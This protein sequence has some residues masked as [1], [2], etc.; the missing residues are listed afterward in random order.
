MSGKG[1]KSSRRRR[2]HTRRE[3]R[4]M[5]GLI[6]ITTLKKKGRAF[7]RRWGTCWGGFLFLAREERSKGVPAKE[8]QQPC[9]GTK[10]FYK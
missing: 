10:K 8:G 1:T 3:K 7:L 4:I 6:S 5:K 2:K 9:L